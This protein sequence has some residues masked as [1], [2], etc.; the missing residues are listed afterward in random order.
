MTRHEYC[1]RLRAYRAAKGAW[2]ACKY[3]GSTRSLS[4]S[5]ACDRLRRE[6]PGSDFGPLQVQ[7]LSRQQLARRREV[8]HLLATLHAYRATGNTDAG[9]FSGPAVVR[10]KLRAALSPIQTGA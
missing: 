6:V 10:R 3:P 9:H 5:A 4:L 8:L 1:R 2:K 7:P